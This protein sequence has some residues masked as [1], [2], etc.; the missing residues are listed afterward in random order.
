M[1]KFV[2]FLV[3]IL[4]VLGV[5]VLTR[6]NGSV[7]EFTKNIESELS[8]K[9]EINPLSIEFLRSRDFEGSDISIDQ[10]LTA[11]SN[12]K[13][14]V[15]SYLSDGNKIN[16]LL[17]IPNGIPPD[18]GWPVIVF[19][20]GYIPPTQY[21][22]TEK[23][24]AYVDGFARSGY[25]VF[26]SDYRGHGSSEGEPSGAYGSN[27]YTI[28]VLNAL[29]SVKKLK[30]ANPEK[31]GM[32]GHSMGGYITLRNMVVSNDIKAG[33]IWGGVVGSY[34]DIIN[35]WRRPNATPPPGLP[36]SNRRWREEMQAEYGTPAEN[37]DFWNSLSAN[38]F[39]SDISGPLQL[40][41]GG[42]DVS[43]PKEFSEKLEKDLLALGKTTELYIYPGDDHN[44]S[45]NLSLAIR[46][47]VE[48]FDKYL[49][50]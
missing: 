41:S 27:G 4:V 34:N 46:R 14:Y 1:K 36:V 10:T 32:W 9:E 20:H 16:A 31:I 24:V 39:L 23:Y 21:R 30:E 40:Q 17:T 33:V 2:P 25:I 11:G 47:S 7:K 5:V 6:S 50:T 43:V 28:D 18:G 42:A 29:S 26:K 49:K 35:N 8:R 15:A 45:K 19:N 44:I 22:T 12:Y 13:R 37:P 48:F 3:L 38:H